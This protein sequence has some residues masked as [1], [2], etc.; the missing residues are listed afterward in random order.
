MSRVCA[1]C[2]L[3]DQ[4]LSN[5][6]AGPYC[7]ICRGLLALETV[8]RNP[9]WRPADFP[10]LRSH[11][12]TLASELEDVLAAR[13]LSAPLLSSGC[14]GSS[15][16]VHSPTQGQGSQELAEAPAPEPRPVVSSPAVKLVPA[17][18]RATSPAREFLPPL[19]SE[20]EWSSGKPAPK[21]KGGWVPGLR[22]TEVPGR[23]RAPEE[24]TSPLGSE[25]QIP[26]ASRSSAASNWPDEISPPSSARTLDREWTG[27]NFEPGISRS[28]FSRPESG[29][30]C[31]SAPASDI[32]QQKRKP[33]K[34]RNQ[35]KK[36]HRKQD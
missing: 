2:S 31:A 7:G 13:T 30:S 27:R 3:W 12:R 18:P 5:T 25:K 9:L 15:G 24:S 16:V 17:V 36:F 32:P 29:W 26:N 20:S 33:K 28:N 22:L 8:L 1:R 14:S 19:Q 23:Y 4:L 35:A 6:P 11:V 34:Q 10:N 21:S